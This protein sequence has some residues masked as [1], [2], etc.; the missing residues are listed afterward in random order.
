MI[1]ARRRLRQRFRDVY[2]AAMSLGP[3]WIHTL[4]EV[5]AYSLGFRLYLRERRRQALPALASR[6]H[7]IVVAAG[8]I[9]GAALGSK[10]SYWLYDPAYAFA[11]F[12]DP[13]HLLEGKSI[14]G[15]LLGGLLGVEL[16]KRLDGVRGSTGDAFVMPLIA[17]MV[18]GRIGCF[19]AGLDDHTYGNPTSLPWGVDFGDGVPRHPTQLYEIAFLLLLGGWIALRRDAFARDGDRFRAFM[20]CYLGYRLL[21]E[22]IRPIPLHY[23][24]LLSGLQLLCIAGLLYYLRDVPRTIKAMTWARS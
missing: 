17:G 8:A 18:V 14:I 2:T 20:I 4:F 16:A 15:A 21:I 13:R 19:L 6:E 1:P 10:L 24:G 11:G 9:I 22:S 23:F 12:P 5:A 3:Y 7:A